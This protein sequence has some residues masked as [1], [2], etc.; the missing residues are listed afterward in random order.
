MLAWGR[1]DGRRV[2]SDASIRELFLANTSATSEQLDA[3]EE[4]AA[5]TGES[6][7]AV[8]EIMGAITH[9]E[10]LWCLAAQL[11]IPYVDLAQ[12][13]PAPQVAAL[14]PAEI[15]REYHAVPV[16]VTV[17]VAMANP[18]GTLYVGEMAKRTG[19]DLRAAFAA[20]EDVEAAL[21]RLP[22][23]ALVRDASLSE[24]LGGFDDHAPEGVTFDR[25]VGADVLPDD[26][27]HGLRLYLEI[28]LA[29]TDATEA[30]V[31]RALVRWEET[32][33]HVGRAL[34][35]LGAITEAERVQCQGKL[36]G[37]AYAD[38]ESYIPDSNLLALVPRSQLERGPALVIGLNDEE[39]TIDLA[40][41]NPQ[42]VYLIDAIQ[43]STGRRVR[44]FI[45]LEKDIRRHLNAMDLDGCP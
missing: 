16:S 8:L 25:G 23:P 3:A 27:P 14:I 31:A 43:A 29:D 38:L 41:A 42:D 17:T 2:V 34:V 4:L 19:L 22:A 39:G 36:W 32:G 45:A 28:V 9:R 1:G 20:E 15:Q 44:P 21:S 40:M 37:I 30:D 24:G 26:L 11:G 35:G 13:P 18:L 5:R 33:E 12:N 10:R 6:L 7:G